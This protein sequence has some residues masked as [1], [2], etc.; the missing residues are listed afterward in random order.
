MPKV[1]KKENLA[2]VS[3]TPKKLDPF[4]TAL[5]NIEKNMGNK[6]GRPVIRK[7]MDVV[8]SGAQKCISFG[9]GSVDEASNCNG[10][11][12]GKVIEIFGPES[13][14][15]SF[16]TLKLIASAQKDGL[17]CCLV[18]AEKSFDPD[19][20][21]QHGVNTDE[22]F[23][24]N[25]DLSAEKTLDYVVEMCK[26]K[27]FGLVV[28]DSTAALVPQKELDGSIED[29]DYAL[30][31]RALSKGLKK[32]VQ[33]GGA[34][35]T[36]TVF[37]NQ[38][39]E[40]M[41]VMFGDSETTP[42]GRALKFYAHQRIKVTPGGVIKVQDGDKEVVVARKSYVKFVKN[43]VARPWGECMIEIVFDAT[44][45]NPVVKLANLARASGFKAIRLKDGEWTLTKDFLES[46]EGA[47]AK[48]ALK[49]GAR[50]ALDMCNFLIREGF[51]VPLINY[52]VQQK[53]D[54]DKIEIDIDKDILELRDEPS[55]IVS[56]DASV[57]FVAKGE[58]LESTPEVEK[59]DKEFAEKYDASVGDEA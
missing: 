58:V 5:A 38:I 24:I 13:G 55:K 43:K 57:K 15:K 39:R 37:I 7:A 36:T 56:P 2:P 4:N 1:V 21:K 8:A 42:G 28:V 34:A 29:Q 27:Q 46:I 54:N 19:W 40:K 47:D 14:G 20:A 10:V 59:E 9:Y 52:L 12:R 32:I 49:T 31:A 18:D 35:G 51:V 45:L 44:A 17:V 23:I 41:G 16:L 50:N 33:Y 26:S 25:D 3:K 48:Q 11:G 30:L 6:A 22:L 53:E